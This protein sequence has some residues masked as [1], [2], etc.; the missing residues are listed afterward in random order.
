MALTD[1]V[2]QISRNIIGP[3]PG[4]PGKCDRAGAGLSPASG[5]RPWRVC[6]VPI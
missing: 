2:A 3:N 4:K 6:C 1:S 5:A